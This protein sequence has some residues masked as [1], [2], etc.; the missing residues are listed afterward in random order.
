MVVIRKFLNFEMTLKIKKIQNSRKF[1]QNYHILDSRILKI[2]FIIQKRHVRENFRIL[3]E[4]SK[5]NFE[6]IFNERPV[7][8]LFILNNLKQA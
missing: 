3:V 4:K 7:R 8:P 2:S 6:D 1:P 5:K